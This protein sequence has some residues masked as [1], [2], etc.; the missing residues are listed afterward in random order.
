MM[1]EE[2]NEEEDEDHI[3]NYE[4]YLS[5]W[6]YESKGQSRSCTD[7]IKHFFQDMIPVYLINLFYN[8]V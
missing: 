1:E 3:P 7:R 5:I 2:M 4:R 6:R 8:W